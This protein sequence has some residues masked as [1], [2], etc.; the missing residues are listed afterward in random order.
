MGHLAGQA[1]IMEVE[2]VGHVIH[3]PQLGWDRAGNLRLRQIESGRH[4]E[5]AVLRRN[6]SRD[7]ARMKVKIRGH[8]DEVAELGRKGAGKLVGTCRWWSMNA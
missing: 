8:F 5:I 6:R 2:P 4:F 1:R 3:L 7:L